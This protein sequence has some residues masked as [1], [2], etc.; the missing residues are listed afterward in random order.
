[1]P[2]EPQVFQDT[3]MS[4]INV[5]TFPERNEAV[6][7]SVQLLITLSRHISFK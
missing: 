3:I 7:R 5:A 6:S 2:A 1:M 4:N